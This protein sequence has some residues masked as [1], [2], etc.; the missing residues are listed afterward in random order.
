[1]ADPQA[2]PSTAW[3][4]ERVPAGILSALVALVA[5]CAFLAAPATAAPAP[6]ETGVSYVLPDEEPVVAL[7]HVKQSGSKLAQA[8]VRWSTVAP[9]DLPPAWQPE[10]PADP[11]YDWSETDAW[12]QAAVAA[13]VT[14][15]LQIRSAPAWAQ[16][17]PAEAIDTGAPCN[18]DPAALAAFATA[19]AR[20][21]NGQFGGL[22]RV[23]YWQG[24]NEPNLSLFFMPQYDGDKPVSPI[25]YRALI[26]AFYAAVKGVDPSNLV[27]AAGLGPI[28]VPKYT[29]GPARFTR[30]LLCMTGGR[31]PRPKPGDCEGGVSFDIFDI[32]PY[33]TGGPTHEGGPNDVQ[34]GDL[35]K[36]TTLLAAADRAG[37]INGAFSHTPLW[38]TEFS[39]DSNPPDP[40]GLSMKILTRWTAEAMH[41]A[42]SA[43]VH[44]FFWFSLRDSPTG[45]SPY[46]ETLQSG[47]Y[48]RGP[49]VAQDQP[50]EV[51]NAF[52]F[53]FV[54]YP[55]T[56]GLDFW[57][58]TPTSRPG[59][60]VIQALK[61]GHWRKV[62]VTKANKVGIFRGK[63]PTRY[64]S[65]H[66][67]KIRAHFGKQDS[68]PFAMRGI[69]D[70]QHPPF[71]TQ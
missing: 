8:P 64:G 65:N 21:Y 29:I 57:G 37:R 54:A 44:T 69:P 56:K 9:G 62:F 34:I 38:I 70:F 61:K 26:N 39:W 36:L 47:L 5:A 50:K 33:T 32:H 24:L 35:A 45:S 18:P 60:V 43:G 6:L 41:E 67:G 48:L 52:R 10:D 14:P 20:R 2:S 40:G 63:A 23:R 22:P 7:E 58:R 55:G 66:H 4:V 11:N 3:T 28:A 13:G 27:I 16:R 49:T 46:G 19:A 51:L 1:L 17:C 42:W 53:P 15:V 12:V 71:G 25:L 59:R 30:L 68:V 31:H